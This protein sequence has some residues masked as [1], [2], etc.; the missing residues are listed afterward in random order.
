MIY[1]T[2]RDRTSNDVSYSLYTIDEHSHPSCVGGA[3]FLFHR[4]RKNV[5]AM[6]Q[7]NGCKTII[8]CNLLDCIDMVLKECNNHQLITI[9][10]EFMDS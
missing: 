4:Y 7:T 10:M 6:H 9:I 5:S 1:N 3:V 8:T 2:V